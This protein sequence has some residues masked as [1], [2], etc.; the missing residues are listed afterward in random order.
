MVRRRELS[1]FIDESGDLGPAQSHSPFYILALVFHDQR[2]DITTHLE[3]IHKALE[4]RGLA[5]D[6]AIHTGPLI[7]REQDYQAL[8]MSERRS[9]FRV[10]FDFVRVC[11]ITHWSMTVSKREVTD[12]DHLVS[13]TSS[14]RKQRARNGLSR[15]P[16]SSPWIGSASQASRRRP[17]TG[18][19]VFR[20]TSH[21]VHQLPF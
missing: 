2:D 13:E 11:D 10:L 16:T 1:I 15:S 19:V 21:S 20:P 14:P 7:R 17:G 8:A 4:S 12:L 9:I 5:A 3:R 6:H 18:R